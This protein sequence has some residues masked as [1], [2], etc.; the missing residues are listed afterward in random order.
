MRKLL[1]SMALLAVAAAPRVA[2]AELVLFSFAPVG[3]TGIGTVN[4]LLVLHNIGRPVPNDPEIGCVSYGDVFGQFIG[5]GGGCLVGTNHTQTGGAQSQTRTLAEIGVTD[6]SRFGIVLNSSEPGGNALTVE[7]LA[8]VI[9]DPSGN[10]LFSTETDMNSLVLPNT[11]TGTGT[12][13]YLF[14][15]DDQQRDAANLAG[16][17]ANPDNVIGFSAELSDAQGGFETF[18]AVNVVPEPASLTLLV[19]GLLGLVAARRRSGAV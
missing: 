2:R 17:F 10:V 11:S 3:G 19:A 16:A 8:L 13:G 12:S 18:Y 4:T 7:R 15:L 1:L 6:A 14:V 5:P 9:Y